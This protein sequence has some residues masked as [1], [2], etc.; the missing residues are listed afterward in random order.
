MTHP[1]GRYYKGH[2]NKTGQFHGSGKYRH[3]DG[4]LYTGQFEKNK[5]NGYGSYSQNGTTVYA[6]W[7]RNPV[8]MTYFTARGLQEEITEFTKVFT[9]DP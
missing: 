5:K 7:Y 1:D 2:I 8:G 6:R 4:A 3:S 9:V